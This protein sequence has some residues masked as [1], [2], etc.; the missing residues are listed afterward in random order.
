MVQSE[1]DAAVSANKGGLHVF[2]GSKPTTAYAAIGRRGQ[3]FLGIRF[4]GVIDGT[5]LGVPGTT[6]LHARVRSA[7]CEPLAG[8]LDAETNV[9]NVVSLAAQQLSLDAAWPGFTFENVNDQRAALAIGLFV[10]A[11]LNDDP[12]AVVARLSKGDV[13]AKLVGYVFERVPA[14]AR[15]AHAKVVASWMAEQAAPLVRQLKKAITRRAAAQQAEQEFAAGVMNALEVV[16][17]HQQML[18]ATYQKHKLASDKA[19]MAHFLATKPPS[20]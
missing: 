9:T 11:S 6:Y 19:A 2:P 7:R 14:D 17:P 4:C 1:D 18:A 15:I 20:E 16:A 8:E 10:P 3:I 13:F 5:A 12:A